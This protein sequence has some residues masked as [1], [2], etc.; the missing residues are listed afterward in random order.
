MFNQSINSLKRFV[1]NLICLGLLLN[2]MPMGVLVS[3][4]YA[5][6]KEEKYNSKPF[7]DS[8][9]NQN[10]S[11]ASG[12]SLA[13]DIM[14]GMKSGGYAIEQYMQM[15]ANMQSTDQQAIDMQNLQMTLTPKEGPDDFFPQCKILPAKSDKIAGLCES[16]LGSEQEFMEAMAAYQSATQNANLYENHLLEGNKMGDDQGIQCIKENAGMLRAQLYDRLKEIDTLKRQLEEDKAAFELN[17]Q[18]DK[19]QL[20]EINGL[21]TGRDGFEFDSTNRDISAIFKDPACSAVVDFQS[22]DGKGFM[23]RGLIGMRE[24]IDGKGLKESRQLLT[25]K[26]SI[27][28]EI[29]RDIGEFVNKL[30][31]NIRVNPGFSGEGADNMF[32]S[33]YKG[34]AQKTMRNTLIDFNNEKLEIE[35]EMERMGLDDPALKRAITD[36]HGNLDRATYTWERKLNNDCFANKVTANLATFK[37]NS[38]ERDSRI[39]SKRNIETFF[40]SI[41]SILDRGKNPDLTMQQRIDLIKEKQDQSGHSSIAVNLNAS[42]SGK[43]TNAAWNVSDAFGSY[44]SDCK[45]EFSSRKNSQGYSPSK[46]KEQ[47]GSFRAKYQNN[48][49]ELPMMLAAKMQQTL[50]ECKDVEYTNSPADCTKDKLSTTSAKFCVNQS[51]LCAQSISS[52]FARADTLVKA[53]QFEQRGVAKNLNKKIMNFK[54]SQY[55]LLKQVEGQYHATAATLKQYFPGTNFAVPFEISANPQNGKYSKVDGVQVMDTKDFLKDMTNNLKAVE[56]AITKQN[57]EIVGAYEPGTGKQE[58]GG[59]I[60]DKITTIEANYTKEQGNWQTLADNCTTQMAAFAQAKSDAAAEQ[61]KITGERN[62]NIKRFCSTVTTIAHT[63]GCGKVSDLTDTAFEITEELGGLSAGDS[64]KLAVIGSYQAVC[65]SSQA[66]DEE[67]QNIGSVIDYDSLCKKEKVK[68]HTLCTKYKLFNSKCDSDYYKTATVVADY[69][70]SF[71]VETK[72]EIDAKCLKDSKKTTRIYETKCDHWKSKNKA[73]YS[74]S[75]KK[76]AICG[77]EESEKA[78]KQIEVTEPLEALAVSLENQEKVKELREEVGE[79]A[80]QV[81]N[82]ESDSSRSIVKDFTETMDELEEFSTVSTK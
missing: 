22:S 29:K 57:T 40:N 54:M 11:S 51:M 68:N 14:S 21:L 19:N 31:K 82:A 36:H 27:V 8:F 34:A 7:A 37:E 60:G 58:F 49:R 79:Q 48:K 77:D 61:N 64:Q 76:V 80:F 9:K 65:E 73:L 71:A 28:R 50:L 47:L 17:A 66:H 6:E 46:I 33:T 25:K 55:Q 1:A 10:K 30:S 12:G 59:V 62:D 69:N 20:K 74:N 39:K 56:E 72:E 53:K 26:D 75:F 5:Q 38:Y 45:S 78:A 2:A 32:I 44:A 42:V 63:P 18:N 81:C 13:S 4:A 24:G 3:N 52:C 70:K 23:K 35:G 15:N 41:E 43:S 16:A 67:D